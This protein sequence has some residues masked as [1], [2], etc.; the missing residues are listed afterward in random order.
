MVR[1]AIR[2]GQGTRRDPATVR[3]VVLIRPHRGSGHREAIHRQGSVAVAVRGPLRELGE[4]VA[5]NGHHRELGEAVAVSGPLREL[6]EVVEVNDPLRV[7][8]VAVE[9]SGPLRALGVAVNVPGRP[10]RC[11][12]GSHPRGRQG[13]G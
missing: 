11:R 4:A 10:A 2:R 12:P 3:R 6:G 13:E 7:L 5:V 8:E 1:A 9:V